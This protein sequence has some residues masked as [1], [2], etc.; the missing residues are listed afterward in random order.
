MLCVLGETGGT[1][2]LSA[3]PAPWKLQVVAIRTKLQ[4]DPERSQ[5]GAE[6]VSAGQMQGVWASVGVS[7]TQGTAKANKEGGDAVSNAEHKNK[8]SS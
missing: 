6:Q 4:S 1:R 3:D 7:C 8:K 5:Q 2:K